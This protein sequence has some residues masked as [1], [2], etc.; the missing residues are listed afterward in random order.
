MIYGGSPP[1][2]IHAVGDKL[3]TGVD[4]HIAIVLKYGKNKL[5]QAFTS[6]II[7]SP[8]VLHVLGSKGRIEVHDPTIDVRFWHASTQLTLKVQ[9]K[10]GK[11]TND[12]TFHFP[13]PPHTGKFN[14]GNSELL[15][16]EA[17]EVQRRLLANEKESP[18]LPTAETLTI[19]RTMDE[20]RKQLG[21]V[22]P[23]ESQS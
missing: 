10:D 15:A 21:V 14:F 4:G 7:H 17:Q 11:G 22:Y 6:A 2:T 19:M 12:K 8:R 23:N 9:T 16:Y 13:K 5:A 18:L 3:D 1:E 20:I